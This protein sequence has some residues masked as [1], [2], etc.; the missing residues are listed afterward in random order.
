MQMFYLLIV[1]IKI[2]FGNKAELTLI[3]ADLDKLKSE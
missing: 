3:S 1:K 2:F